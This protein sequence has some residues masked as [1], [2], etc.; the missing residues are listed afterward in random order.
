MLVDHYAF[1][2]GQHRVLICTSH[3]R[4]LICADEELLIRHVKIHVHTYD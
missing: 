3:T 1:V 2:L 4:T